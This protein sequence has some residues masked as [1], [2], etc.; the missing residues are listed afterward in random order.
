MTNRYFIFLSF[1]GTLYHGWQRQPKSITVQKILEEALSLIL[2]EK[3]TL[4]GAGR[5]DAGV[6][7]LVFCAHFDSQ[8]EDLHT[9]YRFIQ[10]LNKYLPVDVSIKRIRKVIPEANARFNAI[11]RTYKYFISYVK[12]PFKWE[13]SW[14]INYRLNVEMMNKATEILVQTDD[15]ASFC[16]LHSDNKTTICK[17]YHASWA[18][19]DDMLIFT[20]KADRFLRNMVRAI[21]GTMIYVGKGKI[22]LTEFTRI[23]Q[24]RDRSESGM[25]AP[26]RG[27]FLTDI[28]Y[29]EY[30]FV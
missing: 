2:N 9:N 15:F 13:T 23:I 3:I 18:E 5:T 8:K 10:R 17:I 25:S 12:D 22:S 29:P 4:T 21:V 30:I 26:A 6:H 27:L 1:R 28:E 14:F 24:S 11:S 16:K 7:A 20:I 19:A